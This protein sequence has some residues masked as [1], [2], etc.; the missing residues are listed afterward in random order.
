MKPKETTNEHV[1]RTNSPMGF[2]WTWWKD[3][4]FITDIGPRIKFINK[5]FKLVSI[6]IASE[7]SERFYL[8][9]ITSIQLVRY[10][11]VLVLWTL[12]REIGTYHTT[13]LNEHRGYLEEITVNLSPPLEPPTNSNEQ[14]FHLSPL[15]LQWSQ[16]T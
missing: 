7:R 2:I 4:G 16:S 15:H 5:S 3:D 11:H 6:R 12:E 13:I 1:I 14:H 9:H 8:S 10:I